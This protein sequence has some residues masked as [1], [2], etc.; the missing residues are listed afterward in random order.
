MRRP[1]S[2]P[3]RTKEKPVT[4]LDHA[5]IPTTV[6]E[7]ADPFSSTAAAYAAGDIVA[8]L[9]LPAREKGAPPVG[10][11]GWRSSRWVTPDDIDRWVTERKD[12][13]ANIG[14]RVL[15]G[16]AGIDWDAYKDP[17]DIRPG[18]GFADRVAAWGELPPTWYTTS[19]TD[20]SRI[21]WFSTPA[22]LALPGDAGDDVEI[23]HSAYRY[24]VLPPSI[25]PDGPQYRWFT[26]EGV[27]S[28]RIPTRDELTP[29][30]PRWVDG[31]QSLSRTRVSD[32]DVESWIGGLPGG[33]YDEDTQRLLDG[34]YR[35]LNEPDGWGRFTDCSNSQKAM[36]RVTTDLAI[37]G[38]CGNPGVP[39]ALAA[40]EEIFT[41]YRVNSGDSLRD[42]ASAWM[43]GLAGAVAYVKELGLE[44]LE[45]FEVPADVLAAYE[46]RIAEKKKE[47]AEDGDKAKGEPRISAEDVVTFIEEHYHLGR[48]TDGVLIAVPTYPGAAR[49][50]RDI[51]SIRSDVLRRFREDRKAKT[52]RGVII[53]AEILTNA[54]NAVAAYAEEAEPEQVALRAAQ[55]SDERVVL[56]LGHADGTLVDIRPEGWEIVKPS[57]ATPLF[58]R[59]SATS[60]LPTPARGGN[61]DALRELLG[62]DA[63][64][65]RWMLVRGWL[66]A[67]LFAEIP[68]P[69]LWFTGSQGSGKSTRARM[70]LSMIEP[71]EGL[72]KEPGR[73]ERDDSIAAMA[74]FVVSYDNITTVSKGTS[75]WVCRLVTG[76][77]DDR[78]GMYTQD[79]L[80]A[81]TY[82]RTGVATSITI[83][84][85]LGSDALERVALVPLDRIPDSERRGERGMNA[86]FEAA[87]AQLLGAILD[88]VVLALRHL[89]TVSGEVRDWPRMAD[90]GMVL[91][92]LDRGLGLP[93]DGGHLA[94]YTGSV[95]ESLADRALDDPLTSAVLTFMER[96]DG[97]WKGS[98]SVLL[99]LLNTVADR[100]GDRPDW[101][102]R[103]ARSLGQ[104]L[105][106]GQESLRRAGVEYSNGKS[107]G[108]R[109]VRLSAAK[110]YA[111]AA[112]TGSTS[113]PERP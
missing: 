105:D 23:I 102:P 42:T 85:G 95:N 14:G 26:P 35:R 104:Q 39:T 45:P 5:H 79:D 34:Y 78:R 59:S 86:A 9:P 57:K 112:E 31:L 94:A 41:T 99:N 16:V 19:R 1:T 28:D 84:P 72:G 55:V 91:A 32:S 49:I 76:V 27:E 80:R 77:T 52:G 29:M 7:A 40:A 83:P 20:G 36:L 13:G 54:L 75:D 44:P 15:P 10:F 64:D 60:P 71:V 82:K 101:W 22:D 37:A 87:H 92:A 47:K 11:T 30:P 88:D 113:L 103:N 8:P 97:Q 3:I 24:A 51:K 100:E 58:R 68:R 69:L 46:A 33:D 50:A 38:A 108:T 111:A 89:R 61:T 67:A 93:D 66:T 62:L 12:T 98:P 53:G 96:H 90:F 21:A 18:H 6:G 4:L 2:A 56:D 17:A 25:H 65:R 109:W 81:M 107:N 48:S 43:R 73:N 74:R 63:G 106:R 110:R 70:V